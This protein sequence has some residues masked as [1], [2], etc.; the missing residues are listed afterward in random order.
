MATIAAI[1][2]TAYSAYSTHSN[3]QKQKEAA[4]TAGQGINFGQKPEAAKYEPIDFTDEQLQAIVG[5]I[6]NLGATSDLMGQQNA[7]IDQD[8]MRRAKKFIPGF[9]DSLRLEGQATGDLL[10]GRLPYDDVLD[11]AANRNEATNALGIPGTG[12][13]ATLRDL[14]LSRLDAIKSGAGMLNGMVQLAESVDP[15]SRRAR[16]QDSAVNPADRIR[17]EMEQRQL[18]QQ[19]EQS[20]NNLAAGI[21]PTQSA[22]AQLALNGQL[23]QP[24]KDAATQQEYAKLLMQMLQAGGSAYDSGKF[25]LNAGATSGDGLTAKDFSSTSRRYSIPAYS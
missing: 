19:S 12:A 2:G 20:A 14:G 17:L 21:S 1:L 9:R 23:N 10:A 7:L 6:N 22:Q 13:S 11:I 16:P 3:S 8:A 5:N 18:M 15:V 4:K 24:G 25:G